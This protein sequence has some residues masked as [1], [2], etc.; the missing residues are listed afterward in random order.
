[1][2]VSKRIRSYM[3]YIRRNRLCTWVKAIPILRNKMKLF[4]ID[5]HISV[6]A[7]IKDIFKRLDMGIE[8]VD[9]CISGHTWVM[10]KQPATVH[11]INQA[12]WK[13]LNMEMI[14]EFHKKYDSFLSTF[15]GFIACHPNC[16]ALLF[17]KYNKPI[18][19]VNSCR[20]DNPFCWTRDHSMVR[21]L[22]ACFMRLDEKNLLTFVSNN[23]ADNHYVRLSNRYLKTQII[24]SLCLYTGM[25][26]KEDRQTKFLI[27]SGEAPDHPLITKRTSLPIG[28]SWQ[29]LMKF[30]GIIHIPYEASTMSIFEQISSGIP[31]FFPT[32]RFLQE[33]W[34]MGQHKGMNYWG[35]TP[36][37][38]EMTERDSFWIQRAD[39]YSLEGSYY[40]DSFEDLFQMLSSF[41]DTLVPER[42]KFIEERKEFVLSAYKE[43][44]LNFLS[45]NV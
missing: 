27:Y 12:T 40:F 31:L 13:N 34:N 1:M 16:F 44:G 5:L 32:K 33:L 29:E 42:R 28:Y 37:Y 20:Y 9:W 45:K 24:P 15:D 14:A 17:E 4:N 23:M 21:E 11:V 35:K 3:I 26:W 18:L 19:V 38:L 6:I 8:I 39:Y 2:K 7:D 41:V 36:S 43:I 10:G 25:A 22:D 30:K